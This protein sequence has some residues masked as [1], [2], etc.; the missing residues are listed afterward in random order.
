VRVP[1]MKSIIF[2]NEQIEKE[3]KKCSPRVE[4]I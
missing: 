1:A 4:S 3:H 2:L